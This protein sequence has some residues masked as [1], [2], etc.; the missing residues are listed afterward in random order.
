MK[1]RI[2]ALKACKYEARVECRL[3]HGKM[4]SAEAR[5]LSGVVE[6]VCSAA[7][8]KAGRAF[9]RPIR[10]WE[11]Q[12]R[13]G[14]RKLTLEAAASLQQIKLLVRDQRWQPL[15]SNARSRK[16]AILYSDAR[17]CGEW[18]NEAFAAVLLTSEGGAYTSIEADSP[19]IKEWLQNVQS[20]QRINECESIAA[21]LGLATFGDL[22]QEADL[23]HFVD[24]TAAQGTLVSGFSK[25][26]T[27]CAVTSAY[28]TLATR[29]RVRAWIGRVPSKLNVADGPSR[30]DLSDIQEHG[31]AWQD[32]VMP[33]VA[34]WR[35]LFARFSFTD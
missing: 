27:L 26:S 12:G 31:W 11:M 9:A 34:P 4:S 22:L 15:P 35:S 32:P 6:Y 23:L 13:T 30:N 5:K 21:L 2:P 19:A 10:D 7:S 17:G 1:S 33:K 14:R 18:G 25:S 16:F 29:M 28:W 8:N 3:R 24:S 20:K